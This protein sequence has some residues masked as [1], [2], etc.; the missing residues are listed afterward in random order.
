[1]KSGP[2]P[3]HPASPLR[4]VADLRDRTV[5]RLPALPRPRQLP[6]ETTS[7]PD[8][9]IGQSRGIATTDPRHPDAFPVL[10]EAA[11]A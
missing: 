4:H 5:E 1:M 11:L 9:D 3:A 7:H 10:T 8:L 6:A 2:P